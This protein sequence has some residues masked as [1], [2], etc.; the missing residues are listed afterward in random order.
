V[1]NVSPGE[2]T[3]AFPSAESARSVAVGFVARQSRSVDA[4]QRADF[5]NDRVKDVSG[6]HTPSNERGDAPKRG[7]LGLDLREMRVNTGAIR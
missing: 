7:L 4:H 5:A 3:R 6:G 2:A 1:D